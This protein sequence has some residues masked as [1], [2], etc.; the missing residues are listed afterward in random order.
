MSVAGITSSPSSFV[1]GLSS[2]VL[3]E[4]THDTDYRAN[5]GASVDLVR[6]FIK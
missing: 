3:L 2:R 6:R 1:A 4:L 5:L